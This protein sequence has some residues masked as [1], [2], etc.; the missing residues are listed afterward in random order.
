[1]DARP[2]RLTE[3]PRDPRPDARVPLRA[4]VEEPGREHVAVR[5]AGAPQGGDDVEA[6]AAVGDVHGVEQGQLR[7]PQPGRQ[8]CPLI[9]THA[10][11]EVPQE[12]AA[13]T[14]PPGH[15]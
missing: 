11:G 3:R 14:R 10:G 7:G 2:E 1:M 4:V 5:H 15:R 12:L 9:G 6:V 13:L 8:R